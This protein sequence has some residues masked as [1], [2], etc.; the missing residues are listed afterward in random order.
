MKL[1]FLL[2]ALL[3][4]SVQHAHGQE[5]A[6]YEEAYKTF[7]AGKIDEAY[8]HLK[9]SL[10]EQED[11]LPSK[12]LMAQVLGLSG[13]YLDSKDEFEESIQAG[14]DR[15][16]IVEPYVK[17]LFALNEQAK[18]IEF[19]ENQLTSSK[20][21]YLLSAKAIASAQLDNVD[22]AKEYHNK[23]LEVSP[24]NIVVL[25]GAAAFY[26][27]NEKLNSAK[28][29]L[30]IALVQ[31]NPAAESYKLYGK[32]YAR[33]GQTNDQIKMLRKGLEID[34]NHA[35]ILRDLVT[36]YTS[37]QAFTEAKQVL[38]D[39]L[40]LTPNDPMAKLLLS[41]VASELNETEL[42]KS[43]LDDLINNLS[44][45]DTNNLNGN[46]GSLLISAMANYAANNL[47]VAQSEF[48]QFLT[49]V[50][51]S[52]AASQFLVDVYERNRN[53]VSA[54]NLL[55][56]FNDEV[57]QSLPLISRLCSIYIKAKQN[58]KCDNLLARTHQQF[59]G[60]V[61]YVQT[62]AQLFEARGRLELALQ[63][64][65]SLPNNDIGITI[66]RAVVAIRSGELEKADEYV[67]T[68]LSSEPD[69][70]DYLNLQGSILKKQNDI[71]GAIA[72]YQKILAVDE[73]HFSANFNLASTYYAQQRF[74][75]ALRITKKLLEMSPND[76]QVLVLHARIFMSQEEYELALGALTTADI[77]NKNSIE[78][79]DAF[80]DYYMAI[81][82]Y[83]SALLK[84]T[85]LQK[86]DLT[87]PRL[88]RLSARIK[89]ALGNIPGALQD[90]RALFGVVSDNVAQLYQLA[91]IQ[92]EYGDK[93]GALKSLQRALEIN[94]NDFFVQRDIARIALSLKN[95]EKVESS[96]LTLNKVNPSNPDVILLNAD[97]LLAKK[98]YQA[99]AARYQS[100]ARQAN[101]LAPALIGSYQLAIEGYETDGFVELFNGLAESPNINTFATHLLADYYYLQGDYAKAKNYYVSISN[102]LPY[103]PLPM[104]LNNLA[105]I[106]ISEGKLDAAENFAKQAHELINTNS[107]VLDTL[108]WIYAKQGR[109]SEGLDLLRKAYSLNAQDGN[110]RFH[111]AYTLYKLGRISES[112]RE[113]KIL[114]SDFSEFDAKDEARALE[115]E[116][117]NL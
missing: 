104:V 56:K 71:E 75:N 20:L 23:A 6:H 92:S 88:F 37:Q 21:G 99:A 66:Q 116:I 78:V 95:Y 107:Y 41:W 65:D 28:T 115:A 82:E 63:S 34:P 12:I 114:F 52:F 45:L 32:Y 91:L 48:E 93:T 76:V 46:V 43:T 79:T 96:L 19:P 3:S 70:V 24:T 108:G 57:E 17:V 42:A 49:Y 30:D 106:Y 84:V 73:Q 112:K 36:A 100:A 22:A 59:K 26:L 90:L 40:A 11:H 29:L 103:G 64:L 110:L 74:E 97:L 44:I 105:N 102:A 38:E 25:N 13:F 113:L 89:R 94:P 87:N 8:I 98:Q 47:V 35:L 72:V 27:N 5:N 15:N 60:Q 2:F 86:N 50:P 39:T 10:N 33:L 109:Y 1:Y 7:E 9:N 53:Y 51:D 18:I 83:K 55:E 81:G 68:L 4:M 80:I 77:F 31:P 111:I 16:L 85:E 67:S 61:L 58:Y 69:N 101:L 117:N 54:A 14:A 62:Q